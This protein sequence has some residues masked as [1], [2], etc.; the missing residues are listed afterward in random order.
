MLVTGST[1]RDYVINKLSTM[2]Q[3]PLKGYYTIGGHDIPRLMGSDAA[4]RLCKTLS[5]KLPYHLIIAGS[6]LYIQVN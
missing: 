4:A 3:G 6:L 2:S 5:A 1:S